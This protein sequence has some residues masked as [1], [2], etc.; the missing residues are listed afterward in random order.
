MLS[1]AHPALLW[2]VPL[3]LLVLLAASRSA[4]RPLSRVRKGVS[5]ALRLLLAAALGLAAASPAATL[6]A[7]RPHL[8]VF[9]ADVSGSVPREAWD[10]GLA[11]LRDA[12]SRETARGNRCAL[13]AFAGGAEVLVPPVSG[14]P[15][16]DPSIL[17][18]R[19]ALDRFKTESP[20]RF[21]A[22]RERLGRLEVDRTDLAGGLDAAR[23][24]FEEG[25]TNRIVLLTD[26]SGPQGGAPPPLPPGS[27]VLPLGRSS[28]PDVA[29]LRVDA[30][31][32]A[33]AGEPFDVRVTLESNGPA[34]VALALAV[35]DEVVPEAAR[36][37]R[38]PAGRSIV[39]LENVQQRRAL[40][41]GV[42]R[43]L[44]TA[45]LAG[46]GEPRNNL[47]A[48]ALTVTGKPRVLLFEGSPEQGESLA[49]MLQAQDIDLTRAAA[50]PAG[51]ADFAA[52]ILAGA[53]REA[54]P[55]ETVSALSTY[56]ERL[57]GG[58]WVVGSPALAG[59]SG[60]AGTPIEGL[61]PVRFLETPSPA[62]PSG[63]SA[64]PAPPAPA[65]PDPA[66][67]PRRVLAPTVA[68]LL[69]VDKSGSM[70]G[71]PIEIV[72]EACIAAAQALS[73]KDAVAVVAFDARPRPVLEFTESDRMD[74]IRDRVRRLFADGSTHIHPALLEAHRAFA[75]DP[76]ARR[77]S[78]RHV[79]LLSDGDTAPADF[80][81]VVRRMAADG[82]TV[83]TVCVEGP[84]FDPSLMSQIAEWGKG[85]FFFAPSFKKV[86]QIFVQE[87]RKVVE[88]LPREERPAPAAPPEPPPAPPPPP[89]P[90]GDPGPEPP[91]PFEVMVRDPHE[92][93]QGL[94]GRRLPP[95]E[96][97]LAA[98]ARSEPGVAVPLVASDGQPVLAMRRAG[99]GRTA[100]WTSDLSG[101][102]SASWRAWPEAGKLVA[103]VVR[104]LSG[105]APD[106]ELAQRIRV[107]TEGREAVVRVDAGA[108]AEGLEARDAATGEPAAI[109][110][111][112]D[113]ESAIR[114]PLERAGELRR[115]RL[116]W[117][118]GR[119]LL[120]GAVRTA[121]PEY[122][123]S[124]EGRA[125]EAAAPRGEPWR[126]LES[127]LAG[128]RM[129]ADRRL[130]LSPWLVLAVAI[131]LPLDVA[132]RRYRA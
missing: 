67:T 84:K 58:L 61:L 49:R 109:G 66:G 132:V 40:A 111:S 57:G 46:D 90:P 7:S 121:D 91:R 26:A 76:R 31:V 28:R 35:D 69:L 98:A 37:I 83:S 1:L 129:T 114:L 92:V 130:D 117:P 14:P 38:L 50:L 41:P 95:L 62:K 3:S 48:A 54:L 73:R 106:I 85:R 101:P 25:S 108:P 87:A 72:K 110:T 4:T 112:G 11:R 96:G 94:D 29:L 68:M 116:R 131:L 8:T 99:L 52:V 30:P 118:D 102:W 22:L 86:P 18:H 10:S 88:G 24:L 55:A 71:D 9:L 100:A 2:S 127:H 13:V 16:F 12:W 27:F 75:A 47:G 43:L 17:A 122:L 59:A 65:L 34:E 81:S 15:D 63:Q 113:G 120:V 70:A 107:R 104:F 93:L 124:P 32:A 36:R 123:P 97:K 45:G 126:E 20:E 128:A 5:F 51:L 33:R 82:I 105:S 23:S 19:S 64:P 125:L 44:V 78:A 21:A 39:L 53:P 115:L 80:E 74:Y 119:S 56:V 89:P 77:A 79:I 60:Y 6:R 42:H 103:Q